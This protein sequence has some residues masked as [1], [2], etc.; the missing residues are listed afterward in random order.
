MLEQHPWN[1]ATGITKWIFLKDDF[2][3]SLTEFVAKGPIVI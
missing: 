2:D 3:T 1:F